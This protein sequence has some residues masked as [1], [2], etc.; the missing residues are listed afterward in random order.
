VK[1]YIYLFL[2]ALVLPGG[3][4]MR[5]AD[6]D[7]AWRLEA[8]VLTPAKEGDSV[9]TA[10]IASTAGSGGFEL[11]DHVV[12]DKISDA[13]I[14]GDKLVLLGRAGQ[15]SAV[16]MFDLVRRAKLDWFYCYVPRR[17]TDNW[18]EYVEF[19]PSHMY[20]AVPTD[21]VLVYDLAKTPQENRL[22]KVPGE[23]IPALPSDSPAH[24]G[25]P[26]YPEMN[27]RMRSYT[28]VVE[29][30]SAAR[31]VLGEPLVM[32]PS[33]MLVFKCSDG[34]GPDATSRR[35]YLVAVDLSRGLDNPPNRMIDIPKEKLRRGGTGPSVEMTVGAKME[36][37]SPTAVRL[38]YPAGKYAVDSV[39]V[40]VPVF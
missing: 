37:V 17:I 15:V 9:F 4:P 23:R 35:D 34:P 6:S 40:E 33:N 27:A 12:L 24:V 2:A 25:M 28:N 38:V 29:V 19:Y 13:Y 16:E 32:L 1:T 7:T 26:I 39:V 21:V 18:I 31:G 11:S 3:R 30:E 8:V 20:T 14:S 5:A 22:E 10:S 36:A